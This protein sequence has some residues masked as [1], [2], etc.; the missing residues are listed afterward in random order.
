[1]K[2]IISHDVD[3]LT[4][5]EHFRDLFIPKYI[6][7]ALIECLVGKISFREM[8]SRIVR[9]FSN[10]LHNLPE[11][12]EFDAR[13]GVPSTFFI[14]FTQGK[15]LMYP[16]AKAGYWLQRIQQQGFRTGV[17]GN[18]GADLAAI[19]NERRK[20]L[21]AGGSEEGGIRMHYL[22]LEEDT[23]NNLALAGYSYDSTVYGMLPPYAIGQLQ[24]FPFQ[25][26]DTYEIEA[27]KSFQKHHLDQAIASTKRRIQEAISSDLPYLVVIFHDCY[28]SDTFSTWKA[29]YIWL[30]GYLQDQGIQCVPFRHA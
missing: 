12:M 14:G 2:V 1:M 25:I 9:I 20:Y 15:G 6:L 24:E 4:F 21:K 7:R 29:W 17:H 28:F 10:R 13:M 11:L 5:A 19:R 18:A 8:T 23:L 30:I 26:M 3:H 27:G 16:E 22:H